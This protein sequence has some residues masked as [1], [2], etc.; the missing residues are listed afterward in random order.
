MSIFIV[1][2]DPGALN[3]LRFLLE[4]E[5]YT[6]LAFHD[7]PDLLSTF[8]RPEPDCLV[9]DYKLPTMNGLDV[10]HRLRELF[11]GAPVILI[12]GHPDPAIRAEALAAGLE[13]VEKPLSQ[14]QLLGMVA[15][16]RYAA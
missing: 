6:V 14:E 4:S 11:V 13:L 8:P 9:I 12:T 16:A 15:A 1:D 2:D 10:V 3:S 7:G 5:G